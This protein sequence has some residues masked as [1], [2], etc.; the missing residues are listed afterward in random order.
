[1]ANKYIRHGETYNGDGTSSAAATSDGGSGAWN[2][3]N[4]LEGTAPAYGG[5]ASGDVVYIRSKDAAG[6][7]ITRTLTAATILGSASATAAG[8]ITWVFDQGDVWSGV[9]GSLTYQFGGASYYYTITNREFNALVAGAASKIVFLST[10]PDGSDTEAVINKG[11]L[12]NILIDLSGQTGSNNYSSPF[13][14]AG[15]SSSKNVYYKRY[16]P[17]NSPSYSFFN[18]LNTAQGL[19]RHTNPMIEILNPTTNGQ[20][21]FA[22]KNTYH[23]I[24]VS[25]GRIFGAGATSNQAL[26]DTDG[27]NGISSRAVFVCRGLQYPNTM[28]M[29]NPGR[30]PIAANHIFDVTGADG[31][32]GSHYE[33]GWGYVTSRSDNYPPTLSGTLPD[34]SLTPWAWRMYPRNTSLVFPGAVDF[35]GY[36]RA[37]PPR[38]RSRLNFWSRQDF[39]RYSKTPGLMSV[40]LT[41]TVFHTAIPRLC[42]P[43]RHPARVRAPLGAV[44]RGGSHHSINTS[45]R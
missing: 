9:A 15:G 41:L 43:V 25:G 34:G 13:A 5:L 40:T 38:K 33:S 19:V 44:R 1:M 12:E 6:A 20:T 11:H 21:V 22:V 32:S 16:K 18:V 28:N 10:R 36:Y 37:P 17:G 42:S 35:C 14:S 29:F 45:C 24:E 31:G 8:W 7:D 4:V 2:N 26:V 30:E 27:Y 23:K 3:I 39:R